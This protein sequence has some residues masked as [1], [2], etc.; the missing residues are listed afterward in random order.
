[1]SASTV[2]GTNPERELRADH[3]PAFVADDTERSGMVNS[4]MISH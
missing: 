4:R 2:D 3:E 1:M